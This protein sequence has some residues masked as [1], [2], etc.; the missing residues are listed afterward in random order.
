MII[1]LV[2][3]WNEHCAVAE[4][5][6]ALAKNVTAVAKDV[7]YKVI[8][9]PI[10][11]ESVEARVQDV[12]II[13]FN[14]CAHAYSGMDPKAW[15][16]FK[17]KGKPVLMTFHESSDWWTRKLAER[18]IAD[19]LIVHD[20]LHDGMPVPKNVRHIPFGVP[21]VDLAGISLKWDVGT[22]GCAFPWKGLLPL[23]YV[24]GK[25]N[26]EL[27]MLLSEPSS[28][29]C[30][31]GWDILQKEILNLCPSV[32]IEIGWQD[33][34][35]IV[36]KLAAC[37]VLSFP[38]DERAPI[39]GISASVRYGLAAQRPLVL[40]DFAHFSDLWDSTDVYWVRGN[41]AAMIDVALKNVD[42]VFERVPLEMAERMSWKNSAR[43]YAELYREVYVGKGVA[44]GQ[45]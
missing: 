4:Y 8:M 37:K 25:L 43:K 28:D 39:T 7:H 3:N 21:N 31:V 24:C 33:E 13:H 16:T 29:D 30:K 10:I 1:G 34:E 45:S 9:E 42:T 15:H 35:S 5:A 11:Y 26:L 38:F 14:Y 20:K 27:Y 19:I 44:A 6:K 36:R 23:A 18:G 22:F 17:G 32:R 41:L 12:D 40:T 2:T